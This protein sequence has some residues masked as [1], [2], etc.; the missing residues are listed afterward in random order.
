MKYTAICGGGGERKRETDCV[1]CLKKFG[2]YICWPNLQNMVVEENLTPVLYV[3]HTAHKGRYRG[4]I[5]TQ[6]S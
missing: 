5:Y 6:I 2:T 3:G 4:Q 1:P